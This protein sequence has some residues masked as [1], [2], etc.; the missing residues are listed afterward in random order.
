MNNKGAVS[1]G[2][3]LSTLITTFTM[4]GIFIPTFLNS[5]G[6]SNK[7]EEINEKYSKD[8]NALERIHA[9]YSE[10]VSYNGELDFEDLEVKYLASE[11]SSEF[12]TEVVDRENER[13]YLN[14]STE[15]KI[16]ANGSIIDDE[17][18]SFSYDIV[19][20]LG[21]K[22]IHRSNVNRYRDVEVSIKPEVFYDEKTNKTNYGYYQVKIENENNINVYKVNVEYFKLTDR[23]LKLDRDGKIQFLHIDN[24]TNENV[25]AQIKSKLEGGA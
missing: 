24:N 6:E 7:S 15:M 9:I 4:I 5:A 10:N 13:F 8:L 21:E 2:I 3:I 22:E 12:K 11:E 18:K 17:Y 20:Y 23:V 14:N 1:F 16:K 25:K 19:L